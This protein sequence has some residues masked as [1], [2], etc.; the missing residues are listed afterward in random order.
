MGAPAHRAPTTITSYM[1]DL[2][3]LGPHTG[4][5]RLTVAAPARSSLDPRSVPPDRRSRTLGAGLGGDP[6]AIRAEF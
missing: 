3:S 5:V 2:H 1:F 6:S 4:G